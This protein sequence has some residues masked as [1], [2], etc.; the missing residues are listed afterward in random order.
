MALSISATHPLTTK[1]FGNRWNGL[2]LEQ[3]E[4]RKKK[5][6]LKS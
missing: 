3:K 4:K 1:I 5:K 6:L 2:A